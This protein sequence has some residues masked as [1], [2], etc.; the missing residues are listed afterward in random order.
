MECSVAGINSCWPAFRGG[1]LESRRG[2]RLTIVVPRGEDDEWALRAGAVGLFELS[3]E[4]VG[5]SP[6]ESTLSVPWGADGLGRRTLE[7][8][9][10]IFV[11]GTA[12]Y[13]A[14]PTTLDHDV[15]E[16]YMDP[17]DRGLDSEAPEL[18]A[19]R[20][21]LPIH[22]DPSRWRGK[23]FPPFVEQLMTEGHR[24][25]GDEPF[26]FYE[27]NFWHPEPDR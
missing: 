10:R 26:G 21:Y 19:A 6:L 22:H 5:I 18:K 23:G 3:P 25:G 15:A 11:G 27:G 14:S 13:A 7:G 2:T 1:C 16:P 9:Y 12:R 17:R 4:S 8:G 20:S 24:I